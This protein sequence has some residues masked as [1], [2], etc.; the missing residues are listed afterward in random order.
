MER[1]EGRMIDGEAERRSAVRNLG[2]IFR[3]ALL[4]CHG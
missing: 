2:E 3:A 1:P 4:Y